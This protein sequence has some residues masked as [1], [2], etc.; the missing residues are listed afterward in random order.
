MT[1][2]TLRGF[3]VSTKPNLTDIA[4]QIGAWLD[5]SGKTPALYISRVTQDALELLKEYG[6]DIR[7]CLHEGPESAVQDMIVIQH[8]Q[9]VRQP[10][11]HPGKNEALHILEGKLELFQF[12]G[13][14]KPETII[15]LTPDDF[16]WQIPSGVYHAGLPL[17][18]V[19]VFR[20]TRAGPMEPSIFA[21]WEAK[22]F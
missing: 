20:E 8:W 16:F 6:S 10:H 4:K 12:D 11:M 3:M 5:N 19:V 1:R 14:G 13:H 2:A 15:S 21:E 18:P 22:W 9:P 7:L 17:T